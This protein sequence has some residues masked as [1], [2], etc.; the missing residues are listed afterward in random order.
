MLTNFF[1]KIHH[2]FQNNQSR[3]DVLN[4]K[5]R[6]LVHLQRDLSKLYYDFSFRYHQKIIMENFGIHKGNYHFLPET[7]VSGLMTHYVS[8]R[9]RP[10]EITGNIRTPH[11]ERSDNGESPILLEHN[12][13]AGQGPP[14]RSVVIIHLRDGNDASVSLKFSLFPRLGKK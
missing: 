4:L 7:T 8:R 10:L 13:L 1:N 14:S 12:L 11:L 6:I 9:R 3:A 2:N 5:W